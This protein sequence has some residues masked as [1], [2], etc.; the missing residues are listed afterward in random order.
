MRAEDAPLWLQSAGDREILGRET[1]ILLTRNMNSAD[2]QAA[3]QEIAACAIALGD[4]GWLRSPRSLWQ[5]TPET[6]Q[7]FSSLGLRH[8]FLAS[9]NPDSIRGLVSSFDV[10]TALDVL[11]KLPAETFDALWRK[12]PAHIVTLIGW[13]AEQRTALRSD[14]QLKDRLRRFP[15]WPSGQKLRSLTDLFVPGNFEDPLML[16][17]IVDLNILQG[18]HDFLIDLGAKQLTIS[19]YAADQVPRILT[20]DSEI[21]TEAHRNLLVLLAAHFGELRDCEE[22]RRALVHCPLVECTNGTFRKPGEAYFAGAELVAI[23]GS[24][25]L[26]AV[27]PTEHREAM[28]LL[29]EWLG[30][31]HALRPVDVLRPI[32]SVIKGL[33]VGEQRASIQRIFTHLGR[34]WREQTGNL[35]DEFEELKELTWLP[36]RGD[37]KTWHPPAHLYAFVSQLSF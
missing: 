6:V 11:E 4:E 19:T 10:R 27:E 31:A 12:D 20:S 8:L 16:A 29:L 35:E 28:R 37:V 23:L 25:T 22:A 36:A 24:E 5:A 15:I 17:S 32:K 1:E 34:R 26:V 13:F 18:C 14:S 21:S 7:I 3:R 9:E 33:P 2:K 30:V